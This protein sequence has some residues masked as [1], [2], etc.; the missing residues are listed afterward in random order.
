LGLP[1]VSGSDY[2]NRKRFREFFH[3]PHDKTNQRSVLDC[4]I[5]LA[6]WPVTVSL[7]PFLY[8]VLGFL[9]AFFFLPGL[10]P[11]YQLETVT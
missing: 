1:L 10:T 5:S 2:F 7:L 8:G 9:P 6:C 4:I 11:F 3:V